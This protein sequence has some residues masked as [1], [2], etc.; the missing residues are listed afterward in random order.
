LSGGYGRLRGGLN[1]PTK[2]RGAVGGGRRAHSFERSARRGR[3]KKIPLHLAEELRKGGG[4]WRGQGLTPINPLSASRGEKGR[5][6]ESSGR[7]TVSAFNREERMK[8]V[9]FRSASD[10]FGPSRGGAGKP[11]DYLTSAV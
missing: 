6:G 4:G 5:R 2:G 8:G 11:P 3:K 7:G 9:I 1:Q 10:E